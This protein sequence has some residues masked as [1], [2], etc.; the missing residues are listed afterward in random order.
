VS[1]R[2]LL[3]LFIY[4]SGGNI[5][6]CGIFFLVTVTELREQGPMVPIEP[7]SERASN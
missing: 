4:F 7:K 3:V 1:E 2:Y 6:F 5:F